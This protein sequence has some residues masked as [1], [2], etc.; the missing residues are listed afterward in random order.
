MNDSEIKE[1][2]EEMMSGVEP[3][4]EEDPTIIKLEA[5]QERITLIK[6]VKKYKT[7]FG[8]CLICTIISFGVA[9][10]GILMGL[11]VL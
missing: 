8:L 9:V 4:R 5:L 7:L 3:Y 1:E 6:K 2:F 11:G 10:R